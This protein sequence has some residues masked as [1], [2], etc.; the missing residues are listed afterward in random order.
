MAA[1]S[2]VWETVVRGDARLVGKRVTCSAVLRRAWN[3][4]A[5]DAAPSAGARASGA[6]SAGSILWVRRERREVACGDTR[7]EAIMSET[8]ARTTRGFPRLVLRRVAAGARATAASAGTAGCRVTLGGGS[9]SSAPGLILGIRCWFRIA[10]VRREVVRGKAR[11]RAPV[12]AVRDFPHCQTTWRARERSVYRSSV[13]YI[14]SRGERKSHGPGGLSGWAFVGFPAFDCA[15]F[16][17]RMMRRVFS[18]AALARLR[19][20]PG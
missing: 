16:W 15:P 14:L 10:G 12:L 17:K 3:A 11:T 9:A 8:V 18:R 13:Y 7:C 1:R 19:L 20:I 6:S 4:P 2:P 5:T